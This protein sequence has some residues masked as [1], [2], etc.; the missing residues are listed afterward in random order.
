MNQQM[1]GHRPEGIDGKKVVYLSFDDG[2]SVTVTPKILDVL[3]EENVKA[4]FFVVGKA[5]E[6]NEVAKKNNKK[7]S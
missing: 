3:K 4:T 2:P 6:E 1:Q 5:V 7:S